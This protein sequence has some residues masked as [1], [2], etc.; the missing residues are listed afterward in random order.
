M[1]ESAL[2]RRVR[3][4]VWTYGP[5]EVA[6]AVHVTGKIPRRNDFEDAGGPFYCDES[7]TK[8]DRLPDDQ[9]LY[10][11]TPA[12]TVVAL[13]CAHAGVVN[14]L[15]YIAQLTGR[16]RIYAVLGGMHLVRASQQRL[17]ATAEALERYRVQKVGTAHCT[18]MRAAG[19]LWSRLSAECFECSVGSVFAVQNEAD[20]A[21]HTFRRN[22]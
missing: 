22:R 1:N 18:G 11:E 10:V 13:G 16:D 3:N 6:E 7:C 14:T 21:P 20:G 8:A 5:T 15:D 19:Y 4:L 17:E 12:G 2:R 9:A